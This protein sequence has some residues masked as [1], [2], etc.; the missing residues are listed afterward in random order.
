MYCN[1]C[2]KLLVD[3]NSKVCLFSK[4]GITYIHSFFVSNLL[5]NSKFNRVYYVYPTVEQ[6]NLYC[7]II[8]IPNSIEIESLYNED[9]L[10]ILLLV[11]SNVDNLDPILKNLVFST[12]D[13]NTSIEEESYFTDI[14]FNKQS[15]KEKQRIYNKLK[16]NTVTHKLIK[17]YT[18]LT[19][20]ELL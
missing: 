3:H 9:W 12:L 20:G 13:E 15:K 19:I 16:C 1:N 18:G 6:Y 14:E 7:S 5:F 8:N 17:Q 10:D 4:E 11:M 2:G